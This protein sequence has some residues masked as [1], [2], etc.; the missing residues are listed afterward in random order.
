MNRRSGVR[1]SLATGAGPFLAYLTKG[2]SRSEE[3]QAANNT[4]RSELRL[5]PLDDQILILH[6]NDRVTP[7]RML[8]PP[9]AVY[10]STRNAP[11]LAIAAAR[12][13][14]RQIDYSNSYYLPL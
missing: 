7:G 9:S 12:F 4:L 8:K 6:F 10:F 2:R 13:E 11:A 5:V 14:A 1:K 3:H